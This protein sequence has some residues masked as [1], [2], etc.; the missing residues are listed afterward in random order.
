[1]VF[2][3]RVINVMD[4]KTAD[5]AGDRVHIVKNAHSKDQ[6][7]NMAPRLSLKH[8]RLVLFSLYQISSMGTLEFCICGQKVS[9]PR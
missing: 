7:S 4:L 1:M 9:G 2:G 3:T 6:T 5:R 8:L